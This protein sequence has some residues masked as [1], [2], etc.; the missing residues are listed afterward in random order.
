[1]PDRAETVTASP[2]RRDPWLLGALAAALLAARIVLAFHDARSPSDVD[3]VHWVD[4]AAAPAIARAQGKP[5]LYEFSAAWC[6]PC[7]KLQAD[8]FAQDAWAREI[9]SRA[10]P[11]RIVDRRVE[12]GHNTAVVDSLQRACAVTGFPTLAVVTDGRILDRQEGYP[13]VMPTM[14]WLRNAAKRAHPGQG[15]HFEMH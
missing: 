7:Q 2:T 6:G 13:G 12:D 14:R 4:P 5:I 15:F 11:V 1:M 8:V 3:R 10:V 9:E